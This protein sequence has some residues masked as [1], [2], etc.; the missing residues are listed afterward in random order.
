VAQC[1]VIGYQSDG[2]SVTGLVV[3]T[4]D[5]D[6]LK[7]AGVVQEGI[8]AELG[9]DLMSRLSRLAR[10]EPLIPGLKIKGTV[11]VKPGVFCDVSHAGADKQG[12]FEAAKFKKLMD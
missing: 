1:V 3:A 5:G 7:L 6:R 11:W 12:Q 4:M 2:K 9:K 8:G 10:D